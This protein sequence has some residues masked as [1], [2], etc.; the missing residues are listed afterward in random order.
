MTASKKSRPVSLN[1]TAKNELFK[2]LEPTKNA[3][4]GEEKKTSRVGLMSNAQEQGQV[5]VHTS[6]KL[7]GKHSRMK[8]APSFLEGGEVTAAFSP[9]EGV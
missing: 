2:L 7:R 9:E 5:H 8:H 4:R 3:S 1:A 6:G